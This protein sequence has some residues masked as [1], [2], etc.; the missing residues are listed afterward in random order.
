MISE[1]LQPIIIKLRG[2]LVGFH[3]HEP[4]QY[5]ITAIRSL[6]LNLPSS[7][8]DIWIS[9]AISMGFFISIVYF[10]KWSAALRGLFEV[11]AFSL[12]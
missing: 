9:A 7:W 2:K 12:P 8:S 5:P 6:L 1:S 10:N 4:W 3:V 11:N